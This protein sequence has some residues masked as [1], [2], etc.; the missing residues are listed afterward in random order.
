MA[1]W[2]KPDTPGP[3]QE[4][5][6][7][8]P[9]PPRLER[10]ERHVRVVFAGQ[11]IADARTVWRVLETSHPPSYYIAP[12][13][14]D[15]ALLREAQGSSF[16]EWKGAARYFDV[17]VGEAVAARAAWAY[18]QPTPAFAAI[19]DHLAVYPAAMDACTVDGERVRPQP[20]GFYGGWITGDVTGP[21]KGEPGTAGW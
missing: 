19:R 15:P 14:V 11:V 12:D 17:V 10:V 3:G 2:P 4:S 21:F 6:W 5:V 7:D 16:C 1:G 8:Y 13:D 9:R 18:P 20:G